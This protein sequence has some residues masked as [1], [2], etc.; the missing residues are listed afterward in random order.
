MIQAARLGS[1]K[2]IT[3]VIPLFPYCAPGSQGQAARADHA[4]LVA[5]LLQTAGVDRC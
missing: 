4:R 2:R 3:A 1:A 5:D